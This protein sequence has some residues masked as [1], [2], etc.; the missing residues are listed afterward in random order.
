V[1][2]VDDMSDWTLV[3]ANDAAKLFS[4]AVVKGVEEVVKIA[5][6]SDLYVRS[7]VTPDGGFSISVFLPFS[8]DLGPEYALTLGAVIEDHMTHMLAYEAESRVSDAR[9]LARHLRYLAD[10]LDTYATK[11]SATL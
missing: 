2:V 5:A 1:N 4:A 6:E 9:A 11:H 8:V 3:A 10:A 7:D